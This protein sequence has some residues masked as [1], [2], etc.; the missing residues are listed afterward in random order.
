[1]TSEPSMVASE[2]QITFQYAEYDGI[3]VVKDQVG[4]ED[5]ILFKMLHVLWCK[6]DTVR[7][8]PWTAQTDTL[9]QVVAH[10]AVVRRQRAARSLC[11]DLPRAKDPGERTLRCGV[12]QTDGDEPRRSSQ[13]RVEQVV[14]LARVPTRSSD[15]CSLV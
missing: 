15:G 9:G 1:M 12:R 10:A 3:Q 2:W 5:H 13:L 8:P 14:A 4:G 11:A 6:S 7:S